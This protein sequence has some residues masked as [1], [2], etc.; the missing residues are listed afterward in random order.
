MNNY[1]PSLSSIVEEEEFICSVCNSHDDFVDGNQD[2]KICK[3]CLDH[4]CEE[5]FQLLQT[6][7]DYQ[8]SLCSDCQ[9]IL[10]TE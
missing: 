7:K 3:H 8:L 2:E 4:S 5:C 10:N 9:I 6:E 1:N